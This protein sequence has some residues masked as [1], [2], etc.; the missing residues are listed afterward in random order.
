MSCTPDMFETS[1]YATISPVLKANEPITYIDQ[2]ADYKNNIFTIIIFDSRSTLTYIPSNAFKFFSNLE[3]IYFY[4]VP[5][6]TLVTDAIIN[7]GTVKYIDIQKLNTSHVPAGFARS[8]VNVAQ[9]A[10]ISNE[11]HT[12]DV[13]SFKGLGQLEVLYLQNNKFVSLPSWVFQNTPNLSYTDLS[14]NQIATLRTTH[15]RNLNHL[16]S[17]NLYNNKI[18]RIPSRLFRK[19][20]ALEIAE[21]SINQIKSISAGLFKGLKHVKNAAFSHN[22]ITCIPAF[23]LSSL[24]LSNGLRLTF[25]NN[26][27][28]SIDPKF[29]KNFFALKTANGT[30]LNLDFTGISCA[31]NLANGVINATTWQ[32]AE[33]SLATC[34]KNFRR[35]SCY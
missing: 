21:F 33:K 7:C 8:C 25:S 2:P 28:V 32:T 3:Y 17:V 14:G 10:L 1:C 22:Q 30:A 11:I 20:P 16:S 27:V 15:F 23:D 13:D 18:V 9:L 19:T 26:P 4:G 6:T 31:T 5:I 34:Y 29:L 12:L 35:H 24:T